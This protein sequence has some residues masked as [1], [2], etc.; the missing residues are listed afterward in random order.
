MAADPFLL[1][2]LRYY[3]AHEPLWDPV[4][5][6]L[7]GEIYKSGEYETNILA[8]RHKIYNGKRD[9]YYYFILLAVVDTS[10]PKYHERKSKTFHSFRAK[11]DPVRP[12][13]LWVFKSAE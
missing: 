6:A 10:I 2:R 1:P 11:T 3:V 4:V 5:A 7:S 13:Y 9:Y 12:S 8:C